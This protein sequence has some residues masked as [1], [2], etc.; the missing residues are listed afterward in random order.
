LAV[1]WASEFLTVIFFTKE[2]CRSIAE[3]D[4]LYAFLAN[5]LPK[6]FFCQWAGY[7]KAMAQIP[8]KDDIA[9]PTALP[10]R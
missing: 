1:V 7:V 6:K 5:A 8:K 2:H 4:G 10:D 9:V 3:N